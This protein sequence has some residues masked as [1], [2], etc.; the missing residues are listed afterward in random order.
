MYCGYVI[1]L[2]C[3]AFVPH[4]H[5]EFCTPE[6]VDA[7]GWSACN[8]RGVQECLFADM[9]GDEADFCA[10]CT[11][12]CEPAHLDHDGVI[13][14]GRTY[15]GENGVKFHM[16]KVEN[17]NSAGEWGSRTYTFGEGDSLDD[18]P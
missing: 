8:L 6:C 15:I 4:I 17:Y 10:Q 16:N 1:C 18:A 9:P 5:G 12:P 3:L 14:V 7:C 13:R 11:Q 2:I